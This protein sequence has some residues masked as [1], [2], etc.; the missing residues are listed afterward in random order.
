LLSFEEMVGGRRG[1][2]AGRS[3][4]LGEFIKSQRRLARMSLRQLAEVAKVSNA[5]LSQVERG[6]YRPSAKV[7]KHLAEALH[8]SAGTLYAKA[9]LLEEDPDADVRYDVEEAIRMDARLNDDQKDTLIR[10]YRGFVGSG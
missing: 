1:A 6:L 8:V 4:P 9:G 2:D 10:V 5:Y 3:S 7:L